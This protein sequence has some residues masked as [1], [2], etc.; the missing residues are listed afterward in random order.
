MIKKG[1]TTL[2][3]EVISGK[4]DYTIADSV[5]ISLF[6]RVHPELAVAL[7]VTDEQPVTGLADWTTIIRSPPRCSIFSIRSMKT[8]LWR[9]SKRN[10]WDMAMIST[11]LIPALSCER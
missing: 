3:E 8:V 7:D 1:S 11:T 10:I 9:G 2:L 4:L 5:A 6:Q